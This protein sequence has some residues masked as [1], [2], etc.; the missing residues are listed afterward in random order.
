[1]NVKP[2]ES[3]V[4]LQVPHPIHQP[5]PP[6]SFGLI[7]WIQNYDLLSTHE[8]NTTFKIIRSDLTNWTTLKFS[9]CLV[10]H[11]NTLFRLS[12][13]QKKIAFEMTLANTQKHFEVFLIR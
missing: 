11:V 3:V 13:L 12:F 2:S 4:P 5:A 10:T 6:V 9:P 1:M 7:V 8:I